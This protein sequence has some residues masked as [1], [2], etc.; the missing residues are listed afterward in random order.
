MKQI[1]MQ[2]NPGNL[3][4]SLKFSFTNKT[5]A[6]GELMQ[7]AR[8]AGAASV[9]FEFAPE[10]KILQITDNGCGINSIETLLTVAESGWDADV[11]AQE[12]PFG[13]GF[14][15]ALFACRHIAVVSKS[16]RISV[17]TE[18]VLSFKPVT[19]SPVTDWNGITRIK[20]LGVELESKLIESTLKRFA[21]GFPIPVFFNGESLERDQVLDSGLD[22]V[23]TEVGSVHLVGLDKP[24]GA[25]YAFEVYL[26]GLPIYRSHLYC[27]TTHVIHLDSARFHARLPDRDNL[28]DESDV[29]KLI[30]QALQ[31][32]IENRLLQLKSTLSAQDFVQFFD[33]MRHWGLLGLLNDVEVLPQQA[34]RKITSYPVCDS[35]L[36]GCFTACPEKPVT[37]A[38]VENR[39]VEIVDIEGDIQSDGAARFMFAWMRD[40]LIYEGCLDNGHWI[41]SMIRSLDEEEVMIDLVN[42]T[43]ASRFKGS[44]VWVDVKFCDSY[45]IRIGNDVVEITS[46]AFYEG[47]E[48]GG[49]IVMPKDDGSAAVLEQVSTFR[50]EHEDYQ[51]AIHET[52]GDAFSTFV[53]ANVLTDSGQAFHRLLPSFQGCPS[54]YGKA[55]EVVLDKNGQ[56]ALVT[57]V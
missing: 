39:Q 22:F 9:Q 31:Q 25:H 18:D 57:A 50:S 49:C 16:G 21:K 23:D 24:D 54:L 12:H 36:Y 41:H 29:I 6:L 11:V 56:V 10:T 5:T 33:M 43:H 44:W 8:R 19:V 38:E 13:I 32:A 47:N 37:R 40:S 45:R 1:S 26:Q 15:S 52:D 28:V 51:E 46:Q 2:V 3:V 7:N 35:E 20:M 42:Q 4:K 55:F 27:S 14:L 48:N 30:H 34:V 17:N 53:I